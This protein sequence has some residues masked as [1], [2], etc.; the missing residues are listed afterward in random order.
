MQAGR[1]RRWLWRAVDEHSAMLD[2]FL[3][4]RRDTESAQLFF[5]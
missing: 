4:E 2:V 1:T 5:H 3:Q